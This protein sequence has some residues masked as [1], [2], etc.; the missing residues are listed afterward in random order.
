MSAWD[1]GLYQQFASE[2]TQPAIDL[3]ARLAVDDPKRIIDLG[4]GPGNSTEILR[5]RWPRA[6]VV[7]LDSSPE[8]ISA[9][10][11]RYPEQ[12]WL[13][14]DAANWEAHQP[15]DI[16]FSNAA[17]QW[18]PDHAQLLPRLLQQVAEGGMLAFQIPSHVDSQLH[19]HMLQLAD[20]PEW[21]QRMHEAKTALTI[22]NPSFYYDV[23]TEC[24]AK[25]DIFEIV[26]YHVMKDEEAIIQWISSTGLRPFLSA[27][28]TAEQQ[29]RFTELLK[30][31]VAAA[32]PC[33][34]NGKVLFPFRRLF[35]IA[36]R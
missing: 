26:Y 20:E 16:V 23:L 5:R 30:T 9:A 14:A 3:V 22:E 28:E 10:Q 27:L 17:L 33:Q 8:M 4:C 31:R 12:Q 29:L 19:R 1:A 18:L 15:Y 32:Y 36:Y 21:A 25:V 35:V 7:G 6:E 24:A 11:A 34:Q 13:L 2:R